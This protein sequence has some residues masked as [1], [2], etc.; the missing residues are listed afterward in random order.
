MNQ[1]V[2]HGAYGIVMQN[3]RILLTQ[4]KSGPYK[5]LWGLPGGAIEFGE[6]PEDALRRE[7]LEETALE[8][9]QLELFYI[10][11]STG[12]YD[13]HGEQ[14]GF[15]HIGIIYKVADTLSKIDRSP[16]EQ[17]RWI[18]LAAI[19]QEQLTPFAKEALSKIKEKQ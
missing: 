19:N 10:A 1:I 8:A 9:G 14:Y 6:T 12:E 11:T 4:K 2:R 5:G 17:M 15:H 16:E 13:N 7:L 18:D 3:S